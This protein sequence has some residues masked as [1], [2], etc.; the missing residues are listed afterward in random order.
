MNPASPPGGRFAALDG[1]RGMAALSVTF[2]HAI[3]YYQPA[4]Q[5]RVMNVPAQQLAAADLPMKIMLTVF[6]GEAA[7]IC[8]YILSGL[9]LHHSLMR[10]AAGA[11]AWRVAAEFF[12]RRAARLI[13][14]M[15]STMLFLWLVAW[16]WT[17]SGGSGFPPVSLEAALKN[18]FLLEI[19]NFH[20][21]SRSVQIEAV[22]TPFLLAGAF[23]Y[24]WAGFSGLLAMALVSLLALQNLWVVFSI[25]LIAPY[26]F[27]FVCGMLAATPQAAALFGT[28]SGRAVF[29]WLAV[30]LGARHLAPHQSL[31]AL[32]VQVGALAAMVAC[33]RHVPGSWPARALTR[34]LPAFLGRIS[35]SYYLLNVVAIH[36]LVALVPVEPASI[37]GLTWV[38]FGMAAF[39][40]TVPFAMLSERFIER[41]SI[42]L[43]HIFAR[44]IA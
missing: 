19:G 7:V 8:F 27:A 20:G 4:L 21:P 30:G 16:L 35:Y 33:L 26:L 42:R 9:V 34:P 38:F 23:I 17:A 41:P 43:S 29:M 1:L 36:V 5:D 31:T 2:F 12:W 18:A 10:M 44:R 11:G 15:L 37:K 13:P 3:L 39:I 40:L 32:I 28:A 25:P 14:A 6:D 24:L 22:A